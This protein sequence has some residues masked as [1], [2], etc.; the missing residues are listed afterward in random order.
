MIAYTKLKEIF[1]EASLS[2]DIAGILHWDMSTMMPSNSRNQ[3]AEQLA[4][5]SKLSHDKIS[6]NEVRDL[7]SEAKNEDL[8]QNDLHNLREIER[9]HKLKSSV[10]SELVQ[11]ISRTA[12]KC[13]G[14]WQEARKNSNFNLIKK[15]LDELIHL[16]KEEASILGEEFN[17]SPYE[18]L[19]NKFEPGSNTQLIANVFDDLQQFL[20]PLIDTIIEKQKSQKI[21]PI[22]YKISENQ[23]KDIAEHIMKIIG[24]DF[25]RGRLDKSV[26]PFCGGST[27]DVRITTRYNKENPFSSL[28]GVMHE[29][30]HALYE[31]NLPMQWS[32]QPVGKSRGMAM[33]ESQSLMIEM[34]ITRSLA[35]KKFLSKLLKNNFNIMD[36]S[37][38]PDNLYLLG[39]RVEKSFIRVESD[40]VTYPLHIILRFNLE[41]KIFNN[42]IS[43]ND[44]PEVW[45]E[46]YKKL[47]DRKVEKDTDGCLQDVHWYAGLFGY[48]PTYSLGALTAAQFASQLRIDLPELDLNIEKGKFDDLVNWLK[49][50]IHEKASFFSTNEVL[51][52]VTNSGLNAKYFK[53]Y[54]N[55]RYL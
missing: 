13:E 41:K 18:A 49:T 9:E 20:T 11:T 23:Q 25:K 28:D 15:S 32:H 1:R 30:G 29:T 42:E 21:I 50:N 26:H 40:E 12:A 24:F 51:E 33:H 6:S 7:I 14:E 39:T 3:R 36:N 55:N 5:L 22:Q 53:N 19:V 17:L 4:Y 35:F 2:A 38:D 43:I 44:L 48:F 16:T 45:N 52:Q 47:F 10:P 37:F 8:N 46:E 54:I 27:N 34:Q 31:L